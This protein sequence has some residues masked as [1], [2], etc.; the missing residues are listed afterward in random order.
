[1]TPD[2]RY[3]HGHHESVL[4]S[5]RWRT[6]ENSVAFLV[7]LLTPGSRVLDVGCGPATITADIADRVAP[8]LVTGI[9]ASEEV[10]ALAR[11]EFA[12]VANLELRVDDV[13][14]LAVEDA[15]VDLVLAHQVL[16]HLS[17]PVAALRELRRVVAP[18]GVVAARDADFAAFAWYPE[19]P[20]LTRWMEIYHQVTARNGA[21]CDAGRRLLSW[22][23]EAGFTRVETSSSNW[24]F[25]DREGRAFWGGLWAD[26]VRESA[27]A[28]QALEYGLSDEAE[29]AGV[30]EAFREWAR[31]D[32]GTFLAVNGEV[33]A[34]P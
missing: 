32:D 9:D 23:L 2:D 7:P 14:H 24:T 34:R 18:D 17:D 4:R 15:S 29:L 22:A 27:F 21:Q 1:M 20:R 5:H 12:G 31:R 30:A 26:R 25:A 16:Q 6:V 28:H 3:T 13:Y 33:L 8:G 11:A 10:I 19:D